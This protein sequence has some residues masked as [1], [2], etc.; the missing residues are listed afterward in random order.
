MSVA[1]V[2][3]TFQIPD[4]VLARNPQAQRNVETLVLAALSH[5]AL[6]ETFGRF[7]MWMTSP[8]AP[9]DIAHAGRSLQPADIRELAMVMLLNGKTVAQWAA[10]PD[11][12]D[13]GG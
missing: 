5:S 9:P 6:P 7:R 3:V 1:E 11:E 12:E 4:E 10:E 13:N 2:A 8:A